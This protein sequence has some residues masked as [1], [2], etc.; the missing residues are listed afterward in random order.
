MPAL[1]NLSI[2]RK[3]AAAFVA[4]LV[5]MSAV[6]GLTY[7]KVSSIRQSSRW[8]D[9]TYKVLEGVRGIMAS[10]V[11][12]ETG[13]RGYLL[14]GDAKFLEPY[15]NGQVAFA[16]AFADAKNLTSDNPAQQT[17]LDEIQ[18]LVAG[19]RREVADKEIGLMD[20]A[21]TQA[22]AKQ[23]ETSGA[24][25]TA[26]DV[27][28]GQVAA[29]DNAERTLLVTQSA[30]EQAAFAAAFAVTVGGAA[31]SLLAAIALGWLLTRAIA[32]P[33]W[34]LTGSMDRL[35][36]G[37]TSVGVPGLARKDEI[38]CMAQAVGVF[39]ANAIEKVRQ[40]SAQAKTLKRAAA[41]KTRSMHELAAGFEIKVA[42]W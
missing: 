38:G 24:G 27:I 16:K 6:G 4:L 31:A 36:K 8:T 9:H 35:A 37:D 7:T 40:E 2:G 19:W 32:S 15:R 23:I 1:A 42:I 18:S 10:M 11:D 29:L 25:K 21:E 41:D 39:K 3:L 5:L 17:R 12:Q 34:L 20:K 33:V 30:D 14:A 26:T 22:Q 28:R 13:L